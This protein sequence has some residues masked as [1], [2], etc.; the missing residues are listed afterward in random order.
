MLVLE[1]RVCSNVNVMFVY[2]QFCLQEIP[3]E[4]RKQPQ[5]DQSQRN[6]LNI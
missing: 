6:T 1:M 4:C 2:V 5:L 3:G